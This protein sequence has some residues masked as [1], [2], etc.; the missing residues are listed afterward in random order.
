MDFE[1]QVHRVSQR[2]IGPSGSS[3]YPPMIVY[4]YRSAPIVTAGSG[5][6][7]LPLQPD[8][9]LLDAAAKIGRLSD[10]I[11]ITSNFLHLLQ[12]EIEQAAKCE[13]LSMIDVT[14]A[15]R[16]VRQWRHVGVAGFG[17]PVVYTR[18]LQ[19][20][21]VLTETVKGELRTKL[22]EAIHKLME[23]R[24]DAQSVE[25]ARDAVTELR[26]S[27]ADGIILGCTEIPL[28]LGAEA[29]AADLLNPLQLLAEAA[30][31]HALT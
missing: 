6:P 26:S 20:A 3:G 16:Q 1:S 19:A 23:G 10:F 25:T 30:V 31:E 4:Y 24:D 27:G 13:V 12:T 2:L 9:R 15:E 17:D 21:G 8:P 7:S 28:L 5:T 29:S 22:D 14:L 18:P 11:V